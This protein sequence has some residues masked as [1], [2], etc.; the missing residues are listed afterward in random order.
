MVEPVEDLVEVRAAFEA[1]EL[2]VA[3]A[4]LGPTDYVELHGSPGDV[5][6]TLA[7]AGATLAL[8]YDLEAL[9]P[10]DLNPDADRA[11]LDEFDQEFDRRVVMCAVAAPVAGVLLGATF[12]VDAWLDFDDRVAAA[13]EP[14]PPTDTDIETW[15]QLCAADEQFRKAG[16][17]RRYSVAA[18]IIGRRVEID[19]VNVVEARALELLAESLGPR[20]REMRAAGDS[21]ARIKAVLGVPESLMEQWLAGH[22]G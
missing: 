22:K 21:K 2:V 4:T 5:A 17:Q 1:A 15:A 13:R 8:I 10:E 7:R 11:L 3:A 18:A 9:R 20:A 16:A 6:K 14:V 19:V 12:A